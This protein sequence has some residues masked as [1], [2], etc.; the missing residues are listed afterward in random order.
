MTIVDNTTRKKRRTCILTRTN[1]QATQEQDEDFPRHSQDQGREEGEEISGSHT[2]LL[3]MMNDESVGVSSGGFFLWNFTLCFRLFFN[4]GK[5]GQSFAVWRGEPIIVPLKKSF[6][7]NGRT[8]QTHDK[9]DG[10]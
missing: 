1:R 7:P 4:G 3:M 10:V 5:L 6:L 8:K 2:L 9:M